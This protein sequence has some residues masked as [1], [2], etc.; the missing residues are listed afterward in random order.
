M[1]KLSD[2]QASAV[3]HN[4]NLLVTA[5]P[6]SGKTRVLTCRVIRGLEDLTSRQHRVIALTFTNRAADEIVSRLD[7]TD[8][9]LGQLW[10]GTIH[11]FALDW[12]LRPYAPYSQ[13]IQK[14]FAIAD[15]FYIEN[16]LDEL[17]KKVNARPFLAVNTARDRQGFARNDDPAAAAICEAYRKHLEDARLVDYEDILFLAYQLLAANPEIGRTL[18]AVIRLICVD[19]IQ[20]TQDLQYGI[21]SQV[22]QAADKAPTIFLVGDADQSIYESLGSVTKDASEIA[23]E[24]GLQTIDHQQLTGNYRSSQRVIDYYQMLRPH[25]SRIMSLGAHGSEQG[26]ITFHD[27]SVQKEDLPSTI[28]GLIRNA[29]GSGVPWNEICVLA[30][31]WWHVRSIGRS[32]VGLLPDIDF[33]APGLSP[34]HSQR[35]NIWFQ[36]ARLFLTTPSPALYRTRSRWA[37]EVIRELEENLGLALPNTLRMPRQFLRLVNSICSD[38]ESGLEYLNNVF[39][40]L[41]GALEIDIGANPILSQ[42]REIFFQRAQE[43]INQ[44]GESIPSDT[45]SFRKLFRHPSG[46]VI[47]TCHGIKGEEYDTVIGFGLLKGYIPNWQIIYDNPEQAAD[48]ESKLLYVVCSR[49]KRRLHLIAENGRVTKSGNPYQTATLLRSIQYEYD[50]AP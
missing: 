32:L 21:L 25:D 18:A 6:G 8:L 47:S 4:G 40:I 26:F 35:E 38:A 23:L 11:S 45:N 28:A 15:E 14:G 48:R 12:I 37:R 7:D 16:L 24:F 3:N 31:H 5:C 10:A 34:L 39:T 22:V 2:E 42:A 36:I 17:R 50:Q 13:R 27:H 1:R 20:D 29:V 44:L 41:A 9:P 19:E 49:A 33:D 43:R 46:V 30:P